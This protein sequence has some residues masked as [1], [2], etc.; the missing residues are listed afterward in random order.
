M[1]EDYFVKLNKRTQ[2]FRDA[3]SK[4][5][6]AQPPSAPKPVAAKTA[7]ESKMVKS[8]QLEGESLEDYDYM[9]GAVKNI[10]KKLAPK[11]VMGKN[12]SKR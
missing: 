11:S 12:P 7:D 10:G 1:A 5:S 6:T 4:P 3:F 2:P 9:Q 8:G